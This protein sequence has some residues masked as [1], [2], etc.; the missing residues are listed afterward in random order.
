MKYTVLFLDIFQTEE[1]KNIFRF[2]FLFFLIKKHAMS[3]D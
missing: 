1:Q 3:Q 2:V